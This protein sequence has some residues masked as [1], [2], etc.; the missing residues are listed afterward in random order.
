MERR[1]YLIAVAILMISTSIGFGAGGL[2]LEDR[3]LEKYSEFLNETVNADQSSKTVEFDNHSLQIMFES[4]QKARM[5][6]DT[7][8]DGSFDVELTDLKHDGVKHTTTELVTYNSTSYRLHFRYKDDENVSGDGFLT[9]Y[10]I[11]EL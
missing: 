2:L 3:Q 10:R 9:L 11:Q 6:I 7:D 8:V 1:D 5:Y 4:T